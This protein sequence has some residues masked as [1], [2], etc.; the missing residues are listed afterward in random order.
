MRAHKSCVVFALSDPRGWYWLYTATAL[1]SLWAST[2]TQKPLVYILHDGTI[3]DQARA[4]LTAI[5]LHFSGQLK[6]LKVEVG[7]ASR[8]PNFGRF[9][10]AA[11]YRLLIPQIFKD[12]DRVVYLDSDLVVHGVDLTEL[13]SS[14]VYDDYPI[15]AVV[16]Q[17]VIQGF[18]KMREAGIPLPTKG[19]YVN[20]GVLLMNL[21]RL[22]KVDLLSEFFDWYWRIGSCQNLDQDF[23][24]VRYDGQIGELDERFNYLAVVEERRYFQAPQFYWGRVVHYAGKLKPLDGNIGVGMLPFFAY[25]ALVPEVYQHLG[26][27]K[28]WH[29]LPILQDRNSIKRMPIEIG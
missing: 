6:F 23:I 2:P 20:S 12:F 10:V 13:L 29:L 19:R 11:S 14:E 22:G 25:T 1:A 27:Q 4:R 16:D 21:G 24:N 3:N 5:A 15:Y 8:I 26:G 7:P 18:P 17:F 28:L 9:T